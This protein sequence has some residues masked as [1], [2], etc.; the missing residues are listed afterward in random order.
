MVGGTQ[1]RQELRTCTDTLFPPSPPALRQVVANWRASLGGEPPETLLRTYGVHGL[2]LGGGVL[3]GKLLAHVF[4]HSDLGKASGAARLAARLL[5]AVFCC[6]V[7]HPQRAAGFAAHAP[8]E[9]WPGA[10]VFG[11]D[12]YRCCVPDLLVGLEAVSC[13]LLDDGL[14]LDALPVVCLWEHAARHAA[15]ELAPTVLARAARARALCALGMLGDAAAVVWDLMVGHDLPDGPLPWPRSLAGQQQGAGGGGAAVATGGKGAAAAG[16]GGSAGAAHHGVAAQVAPHAAAPGFDPLGRLSYDAAAWPGAP[17]N[18][19]CCEAMAS[20][21]MPPGVAACYGPLLAAAAERA[22]AAWLIA[23]GGVRNAW[24]ASDPATGLRAQPAAAAPPPGKTLPG[25]A[26][27]QAAAGKQPRAG[28][29]APHACEA[30]EESLLDAAAALL[31]DSAAASLDALKVGAAPGSGASGAG[32]PDAVASTQRPGSSG[33]SGPGAKTRAAKPGAAARPASPRKEAGS[34][35]GQAAAGQVA[36]LAPGQGVPPASAGQL[37]ASAVAALLQLAEAEAL[38][39]A[40]A[41]GLDAALQAAVLVRAHCDG[42]AAAAPAADGGQRFGLS[43]RLWLR[44][45]AAVVELLQQAQHHAAAAR[46]AAAA[47]ADCSALHEGPLAARLLARK[48]GSHAALGQ[49]AAASEAWRE[50]WRLQ[51]Q[52]GLL[53]RDERAWRLQMDVAL[54]AGQLGLRGGADAAWGASLEGLRQWALSLG[55]AEM[56][57]RPLPCPEWRGLW[58][59]VSLGAL[60]GSLCHASSS[61]PPPAVTPYRS[62]Q[63]RW[64]CP[65]RPRRSWRPRCCMAPAP[66]RVAAACTTPRRGCARRARCWRAAAARPRCTRR[67]GSSSRTC[68]GCRPPCARR[69]RRPQQRRAPRPPWPRASAGPRRSTRRRW[70]QAAAAVAAAAAATP[71]RVAWPRRSST[72]AAR[73][74]CWRWTPA[75]PTVPSAPPCWSL[76][77]ASS[78]PRRP[79]ARPPR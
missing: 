11:G 10:D 51:L 73:S 64:W 2:L 56:L 46:E 27:Q 24:R 61:L 13:A 57:V 19:A 67:C 69:A 5:A 23:A 36:A 59:A 75:A 34:T 32:A 12:P 55:L 33:S 45:R 16:K 20:G 31:R 38:R 35:Q 30:V 49:A 48:A 43:P 3:A 17:Q 42:C 22:R 60:P 54:A 63:R 21:R 40:P 62:T 77:H 14:A 44:A 25:A 37:A 41:A 76:R 68:C 28:S 47:I 66:R 65:C 4:G 9:M 72:C 6:D 18:R 7:A 29:G 15:R 78:R 79:P 1:R 52:L 58:P 26:A 50:A 8:E 39:W 53:A 74:A 71:R 70:R